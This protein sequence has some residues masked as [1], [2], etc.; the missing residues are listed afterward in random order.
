MLDP[1]LTRAHAGRHPRPVLC[2]VTILLLT[3][4]TAMFGQSTQNPKSTSPSPDAQSAP[5]KPA[6]EKLQPKPDDSAPSMAALMQLNNA[7]EG[8]AAKVSPA[9][10]QI[11]VTGYGP[12]HEENR[13]A[14]CSHR[15]PAC[16]RLRRHR[17]FRRLHHD[18]R[19]RR[20]RRAAHSRRL[21][22]AR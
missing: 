6:D 18:Q 16:R 17:R 22:S 11:L 21:A 19:P 13:T 15:S 9:V 8:L 12:M 1:S 2:Y 3:L 20:R 7:L 14:D 5:G 4:T 10:V